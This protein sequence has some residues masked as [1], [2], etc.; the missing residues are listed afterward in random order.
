MKLVTIN[1]FIEDNKS[2]GMLAVNRVILRNSID[3]V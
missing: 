1:V 3:D 2:F